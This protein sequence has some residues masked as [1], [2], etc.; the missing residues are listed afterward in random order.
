[1]GQAGTFKAGI[2]IRML[3]QK[4]VPVPETVAHLCAETLVDSALHAALHRSPERLP[5]FAQQLR[6]Q[7]V[8]PLADHRAGGGPRLD[9]DASIGGQTVFL[10]SV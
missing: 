3:K 5:P 1:M 8:L 4:A 2:G 6:L 10:A 7:A 9:S